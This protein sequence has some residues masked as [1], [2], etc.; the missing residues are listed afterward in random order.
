MNR[1]E[2]EH[3]AGKTWPVMGFTVQRLF[4]FSEADRER[5]SAHYRTST[6]YN[7]ITAKLDCDH[8]ANN[9]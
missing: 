2:L 3:F 5:L 7:K 1:R 6:V 4:A 9:K 8:A